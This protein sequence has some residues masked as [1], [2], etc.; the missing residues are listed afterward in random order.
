MEFDDL[1]ANRRLDNL[2]PVSSAVDGAADYVEFL[3]RF[4]HGSLEGGSLSIYSGLV[5]PQE[6]YGPAW[7]GPRLRIFGDD[8]AG[9]CFAFHPTGNVVVMLDTNGSV[10]ALVSNTFSAFVREYL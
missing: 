9:S 4:G 8:M 6:I 2:E 7:I 5:D 10:W 1:I 3:K